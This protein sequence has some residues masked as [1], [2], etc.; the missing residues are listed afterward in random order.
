MIKRLILLL[1]ASALVLNGCGILQFSNMGKKA[2]EVKDYNNLVITTLGNY[3][4][5]KVLADSQK[6][7]VLDFLFLDQ[8]NGILETTNTSSIKPLTSQQI[9]AFKLHGIVYDTYFTSLGSDGVREVIAIT[10]ERSVMYATII[11]GS[12]VIHSISREIQSR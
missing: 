1:S 11:W 5:A 4:K 2:Q 8:K 3:A 9:N 12:G 6:N 7:N 10:G